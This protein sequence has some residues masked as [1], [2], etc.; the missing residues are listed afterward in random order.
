MRARPRHLAAA[1]IAAFALVAAACGSSATTTPQ[2]SAPVAA[3]SAAAKAGGSIIVRGCT[4]QNP[5]I[6]SM[7]GE[8]CGGNV[9]D[10]TSAKLV[11]YNANTA[12]PEMDIAESIKTD[13][14]QTFTVTLKKGYK[15]SDGTEVK[16]KNFV[17][18]WNIAAYGPNGHE[19]GYFFEAIDGFADTQCTDDKCTA[20]P[21]AEKLSGLVVKDD[22]TF[23]IKTAEPTSNLPVR[24]GYSAFVPQPDKY[25]ANPKDEAFGKMPVAAGPYKIT[26]NTATEIVMEKNKDY[27]G[28]FKGQVDKVTYRIYNDPAAAWT[29]VVANNIDFT[30]VIPSDQLPNDAWKKV[31]GADRSAVR[32]SGV[33]QTLTFSPTDEQLKGN[34]ALRKAISQAIDR[35]TITKVIYNNTRTPAT[36][37]VSPVVDGY[38]A[39]Q[40]GDLC[41]YDKAKAKAAYDAAGGYKG[42]FQLW[43]N[44]DGGHKPWADAVCNGLKNDLGLDCVVQI[45]PKFADLL[46][47]AKAGEVKGS[48]RSGWQMDYPSI[49]NFL[50]PLYSKGAGSNY[51]KYDNPAFEKKLKDAAAAKDLATANKLYQEAELMVINDM[52]VTPLWYNTTPAA[53]SNKVT[54][55]KVNAFG[56]LDITSITVK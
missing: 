5:L 4:P 32:E 10:W 2:A 21:K 6:G 25:L 28:T 26:S 13:D 3:S 17:E 14:S 15:F 31:V 39:D 29:D 42:T 27:S 16:A 30:D 55:V 41:K 18:A 20:K 19:G 7:T 56:V 43:V 49:E 35:A 45:T 9:I 12:Q 34:V 44:Q 37:L 22:Y 48:H 53:W 23:T 51:S 40:C 54:N 33:I 11:H 47:K 24:L 8:V 50:A 36:G 46:N 1:S 52:P 38:K